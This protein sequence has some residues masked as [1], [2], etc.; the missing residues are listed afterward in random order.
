MSFVASG[1]IPTTTSWVSSA[2]CL[3]IGRWSRQQPCAATSNTWPERHDVGNS[4]KASGP[5]SP[6]AEAGRRVLQHRFFAMR[7][8]RCQ[9][10]LDEAE[11]E[12]REAGDD[13]DQPDD[14]DVDVRQMPVGGK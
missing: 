8:F 2:T 3:A 1:S 4:A 11:D 10:L 5:L 13:Q 9:R 12:T 14:V 7:P 6:A